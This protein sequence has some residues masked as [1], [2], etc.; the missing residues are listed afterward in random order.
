MTT[1]L[2]PLGVRFFFVSD[3]EDDDFDLPLLL[4]LPP[5]IVYDS[6][7]PLEWLIRMIPLLQ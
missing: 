5:S 1:T 2:P 7:L 6:P 3:E 4:P